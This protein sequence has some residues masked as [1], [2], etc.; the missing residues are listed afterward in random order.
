MNKA[1]IIG[2]ILAVGLCIGIMSI[3]PHKVSEEKTLSEMEI[4]AESLNEDLELKVA[5]GDWDNRA[6]IWGN[7][8]LKLLSN[9]EGAWAISSS[10]K[11]MV[12]GTKKVSNS[13]M[14]FEINT[15][16]VDIENPEF[17]MDENTTFTLEEGKMYG[18]KFLS[19]EGELSKTMWMGLES[20]EERTFRV[21]RDSYGQASYEA[22]LDETKACGYIVDRTKELA[23][24]EGVKI[25]VLLT[26]KRTH[27]IPVAKVND[28]K[29]NDSYFIGYQN[30]YLP[31]YW[32]DV[33]GTVYEEWNM[34]T[35]DPSG[36][37][38]LINTRNGEKAEVYIRSLYIL[39]MEEEGT[40]FLKK[41][42]LDEYGG[43]E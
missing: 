14:F 38:R 39:P 26:Q 22:Y 5:L 41:L 24:E 19:V 30:Q 15:L 31:E 10:S 37:V 27:V 35:P 12:I 7:K 23:E 4:G 33:E 34:T 25:Y 21:L 11:C 40:E 9:K 2:I 29:V 6:V 36:T 8:D 20:E 28:A 3:A 17:V 32:G 18:F 42:C 1:L 16:D 13:T 43:I